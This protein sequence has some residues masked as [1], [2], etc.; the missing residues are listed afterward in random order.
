MGLDNEKKLYLKQKHPKVLVP[1]EKVNLRELFL[2]FKNSKLVV[3]HDC[4][5]MHLAWVGKTNI[6]DI[7]ADYIP[8]KCFGPANKNSKMIVAKLD[9][10]KVNK[11]L[12]A[13]EKLI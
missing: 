5:P 1:N 6:L 13:C 3:A 2:I 4:G 8:Y 9:K 7:V 10:L 12:K 11:V